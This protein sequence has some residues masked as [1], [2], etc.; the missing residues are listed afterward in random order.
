MIEPRVALRS[1]RHGKKVVVIL[2]IIFC[3]ILF[4]TLIT[5]FSNLY[6][7]L[8]ESRFRVRGTDCH[9]SVDHLTTH[10]FEHLLRDPAIKSGGASIIVGKIINPEVITL[11]NEL[12]FV[13]EFYAEHSFQ[14]PVQGHLPSDE[15]EIAMSSNLLTAFNKKVGDTLQ[16]VIQIDETET[17]S[18]TISDNFKIVGSWPSD[19]VLKRESVWLSDIWVEN[20]FDD[21]SESIEPSENLSC[22]FMLNSFS[23][24]VTSQFNEL[25]SR[26]PELNLRLNP[27][28][29][30][31]EQVSGASLTE[32]L[33]AL[34]LIFVA[35]LSSYYVINNIYNINLAKDARE[36]GR[37]RAIG[38]TCRQIRTIE[39]FKIMYLLIVG[40]PIGLIFGL[41]IGKSLMPY[42]G[43]VFK[44]SVKR[45]Y[46]VSPLSIAVSI[47]FTVATVYISTRK[48]LCKA[49]MISPIQAMGFYDFDVNTAGQTANQENL[50]PFRLAI[51]NVRRTKHQFRTTVVSIALSILLLNV[52]ASFFASVSFDVFAT[53][54]LGSDISIKGTMVV[55]DSGDEEYKYIDNN[56]IEQ[57]KSKFALSEEGSVYYRFLEMDI[58]LEKQEKLSEFMRKYSGRSLSKGYHPTL[59]EC[60]VYGVNDWLWNKIRTYRN[61]QSKLPDLVDG[62]AY[63]INMSYVE[64]VEELPYAVGDVLKLSYKG[65]ES[66]FKFMGFVDLPDSIHVPA[67][68]RGTIEL[69]VSQNTFN[70]IFPDESPVMFFTDANEEVQQQILSNIEPQFSD[71]NG[72]EV[73]S[74]LYLKKDFHDL[75]N[76][77]RIVGWSIVALLVFLGLVNL[78][79]SLCTSMISRRKELALMEVIGM[80]KRQCLSM[81]LFEGLI[82]TVVSIVVAGGLGVL[83]EVFIVEKLE[84][85]LPFIVHKFTLLPVL[86]IAVPMIVFA[87]VTQFVCYKMNREESIRII[88]LAE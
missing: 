84:Q 65:K 19:P 45:V 2:A 29:S 78:A 71:K 24:E 49:S 79:N 15:N 27:A 34:V 86:Y 76:M 47:F 30:G 23:G 22:L 56:F 6:S 53:E 63:L 39:R 50:T 66:E 67:Y 21:T 85:A 73:N 81:L 8:Q 55:N 60:E 64:N 51:R 59:M 13:S 72:Y 80:T 41:M 7:A 26:F 38:C 57:L 58:P 10:Q 48:A 37:L 43:I 14:M 83:G 12:R 25:K 18:K 46:S 70:S 35:F 11:N 32:Y 88:G 74:Y 62:E 82:Y 75:L 20:Y 61:P 44:S 9:V 69:L 77:F 1:L 68:T 54:Q 40:I 5:T 87:C 36:Y 33:P 52:V 4:S 3:T 42:I 16:L 17:I 28:Y 31:S